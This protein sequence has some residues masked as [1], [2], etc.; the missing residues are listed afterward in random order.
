MGGRLED[1]SE[2][3]SLEVTGGPV[4]WILGLEYDR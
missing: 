3:D 4:V 1:K 2:R